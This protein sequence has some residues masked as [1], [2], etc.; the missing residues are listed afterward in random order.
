MRENI[1]GVRGVGML[2]GVGEGEERKE[3]S[4]SPFAVSSF[5]FSLSLIPQKSFIL[6]R[7]T[8]KRVTVRLR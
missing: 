8:L 2:D 3:G 1:A 5:R 4:F 6:R 7:K